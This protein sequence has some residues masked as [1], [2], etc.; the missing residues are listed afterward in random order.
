MLSKLW[1]NYVGKQK[2][3][4]FE[5][6][7]TRVKDVETRLREFYWP[8]YLRL[9]RDNVIWEKILKRNDTDAD[10][11][12]MAAKIESE[13]ILPNHLAIVGIIENG[14]HFVRNDDELEKEVM[15][16]LR[17]ID[18]YRSIRAA[19]IKKDPI[20]FGEPYPQEFFQIIDRRVK[21]LQRQY[22]EILS[23]KV[24]V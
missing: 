13:V 23:Q 6:W 1:E 12:S 22:D 19:G 2:D 20:V 21:V 11:S 14:M 9:Q 24:Q 5:L 7:Q 3:I 8:I 10:T 16:Y 18:V 4:E 17:H 15:H